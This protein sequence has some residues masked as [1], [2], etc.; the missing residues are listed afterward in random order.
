MRLPSFI[1]VKQDFYSR[2]NVKCFQTAVFR[3]ITT[4]KKTKNG[5]VHSS[6]VR[7]FTND[8]GQTVQRAALPRTTTA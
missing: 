7:G 1:S 2:G 3:F 8:L 6:P 5:F 4:M